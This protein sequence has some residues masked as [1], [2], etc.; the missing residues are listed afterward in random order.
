MSCGSADGT[1]IA[2]EI[3]D[4]TEVSKEVNFLSRNLILCSE[5][6]KKPFAGQ[7]CPSLYLWKNDV[8][9][10]VR[11]SIFQRLKIFIKLAIRWTNRAFFTSPAPVAPSLWT[12]FSVNSLKQGHK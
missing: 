8:V 1:N 11:K 5:C 3:T 10:P 7:V 2:C 12:G 4:K 9:S 6:G